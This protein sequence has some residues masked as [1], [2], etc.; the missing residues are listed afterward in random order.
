MTALISRTLEVSAPV[1]VM[2]LL[3]YLLRRL[4]W[5]DDAFIA[6]ASTLVF[7]GSLPTLLFLSLQQ[8]GARG[9]LKPALV[10]YFVVG[11][12]IGVGLLLLWARWRVPAEERAVCVQGAF[13]GNCGIVGLALAVSAYGEAGLALGGPM[14]ALATVLYNIIATILLSGHHAERRLALPAMLRSIALN[15]LIIGSFLGAAWAFGG[16]PLPSWLSTSATYFANLSLPLALIC[17]GAALSRSAVT[18]AW[19]LVRASTLMKLI[20]I[21][22]GFTAGAYAAGFRGIELGVLFLYSA[23]PTAAVSFVMTR[24]F[25]ANDQLA[26][27]II[28]LSTALSLLSINLGLLLL[29]SLQLI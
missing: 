3:G 25:G 19:P 21:P 2:V 26:A 10:G 7:R 27:A 5:I 18:A 4:R 6:T 20:W 16:V 17:V 8:P 23:S 24:A 14:A 22:L 29:M 28:A 15:P 1:F 12:L 9:A 13:R 11:T